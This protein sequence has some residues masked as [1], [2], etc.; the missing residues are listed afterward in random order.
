LITLFVDKVTDPIELFLEHYKLLDPDDKPRQILSWLSEPLLKLSASFLDNFDEEQTKF[1]QHFSLSR[2]QVLPHGIGIDR[3]DE[4]VSFLK[5]VSIHEL[6]GLRELL[7]DCLEDCSLVLQGGVGKDS[8][9][10]PTVAFVVGEEVVVL[11]DVQMNGVEST[12]N[13]A[14]DVVFKSFEAVLLPQPTNYA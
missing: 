2:Q 5:E 6:L 14:S 9:I 3:V 1:L 10:C 4:N 11:L 7:V 13:A 8:Q 12:T